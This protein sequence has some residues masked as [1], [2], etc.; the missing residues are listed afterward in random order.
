MATES[1]LFLYDLSSGKFEN[2]QKDYRTPYAISDNAVYTLCKDK[3]GGIWAGTYFGG[4]NYAPN[5]YTPFEKFLPQYGPNALSGHAVREICRDHLGNLWVG[6]EDAGLNKLDA[7]TGLITHFNPTGDNT[8]IAYSNIHGL[9]PVGDELWVGTFEHGLDVLNIK[10]GKVL[11]HYASGT[12]PNAI[13]SNFISA[14]C[15]TRTGA[16]F[17]GTARGLYRYRPATNDFA[18]VEEIPAHAFVHAL[19][20]DRE[21][22]LW[23]ST[24]EDG[25]YCFNPR[26]RF[27]KNF[28]YEATAK[29]SISSNTVN[30]VFEDSGGQLWCAT[31]GGGLCKMNAD[32]KGF[33]RYTT[34]NGLP[35]NT[36]FRL[37][38]DGKQHLW[39]ST[40]KGL[41]CLNPDTDK[42]CV[43]TTDN[44]LL[45]S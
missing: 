33:T 25:L 21:G 34:R 22:T 17:L 29:T 10:N 24:M 5:P 2:L 37:L 8:G 31:E 15:Q 1:G 19:L 38:E 44:G 30:S 11:R 27:S 7:R 13:K 26:T 39:I 6:T 41:V 9:L 32:R 35:S 4:V 28:R 12:G 36:V 23:A 18:P 16:I 42:M 43:Y 3:E 45:R 20:E 40:A 14:L